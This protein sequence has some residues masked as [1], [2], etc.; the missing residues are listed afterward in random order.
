[1][2]QAI[3]R[4]T[5][6]VRRRTMIAETEKKLEKYQQILDTRILSKLNSHSVQ[7]IE[8]FETLDQSV[9]DLALAL[10][11]G[12][13]TVA[14]LLTNQ[15]VTLRGH[16]DDRFD[17]Q[18]HQEAIR[19][20][21]Q[22]FRDSLFFPEIFARQDDIVKAHKGTCRWVF[23]SSQD[24]SLGN[25]SLDDDSMSDSSTSEGSPRSAPSRTWYEFT[26]WL[27]N[28]EDIYW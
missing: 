26:S 23:S 28:N 15:A 8:R 12:N 21:Q 14:Q 2:I 7:Q 10:S 17:D 5:R 6:A 3:K 19:R 22:Q 25:S 13:N 1:M 11:Q 20:V 16:I 24:T 4:S 27:Q 9:K 18:A